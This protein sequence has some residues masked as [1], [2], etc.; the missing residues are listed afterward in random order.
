VKERWRALQSAP[1]GER[2]QQRFHAR[3]LVRK[4]G[5]SRALAILGGMAVLIAGAVML[6]APGPGILVFALGGV[7]VAEESLWMARWLDRSELRIRSLISA[8][9]KNV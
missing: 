7:L 5:L 6:V 3:R 4:R 2:F 8:L 1:P 9:R